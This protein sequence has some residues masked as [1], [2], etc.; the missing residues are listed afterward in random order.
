MDAD[1]SE[2]RLRWRTCLAHLVRSIAETRSLH[3][4]C[5]DGPQ[6]GRVQGGGVVM[7]SELGSMWAFQQ[8]LILLTHTSTKITRQKRNMAEV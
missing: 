1:R 4:K 6:S 8:V 2:S 3:E 7:F 5:R